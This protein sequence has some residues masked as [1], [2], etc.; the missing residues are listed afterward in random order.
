MDQSER[1]ARDHLKSRGLQSIVY[2]PDGNVPPDFLVDGRIAVE[3]RRLNESIQTAHGM[4]GLE[5]VATPLW[6]KMQKLLQSY[7]PPRSGVSWSVSWRFRRPVAPWQDLKAKIAGVLD[8]FLNHG[9]H[10]RKGIDLGSG[11]SIEFWPAIGSFPTFFLPADGSDSDSGGWLGELAKNVDICINEKTRKVASFRH[12]YHEWWLALV[13]H[14][15][16]VP[17]D[18]DHISTEHEW[19]KVIIVNP[20]DPSM[21]FEI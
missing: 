19:D 10:E 9:P 7:G 14:I 6:L 16:F 13:D 18:R 3:V 5:E 15:G 11:F 12:K 4:Q 21:S 20:D 2:E 17:T 1:I 8:A